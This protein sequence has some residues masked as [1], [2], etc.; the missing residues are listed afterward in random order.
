MKRT[1]ETNLIAIRVRGDILMLYSNQHF[2]T[3]ARSVE[4]WQTQPEE[5][6]AR[7]RRTSIQ[8]IVG[9]FKESE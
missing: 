4:I 6:L 2:A 9:T 7:F 8:K 1:I 5:L 3:T